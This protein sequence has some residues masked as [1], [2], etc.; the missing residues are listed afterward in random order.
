MRTAMWSCSM[1]RSQLSM[2]MSATTYFNTVSS[3]ALFPV[4]HGY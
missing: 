1:T 2:P 3:V 4:E